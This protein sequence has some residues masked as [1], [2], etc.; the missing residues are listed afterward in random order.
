M[1]VD[2][3]IFA[4]TYGG[5]IVIY[6]PKGAMNYPVMGSWPTLYN[7]HEFSPEEL[8]FPLMTRQLITA[9]T[10]ISLLSSWIYLSKV[11]AYVLNC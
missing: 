3:K 2:V 8:A 11:V 4:F 10:F 6:S 7:R 1:C 5:L 9:I